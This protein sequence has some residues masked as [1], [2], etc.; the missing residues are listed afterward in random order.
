MRLTIEQRVAALERESVVLS[1]TVKLL[2]RLLKEQRRLINDYITKKV[3]SVGQSKGR[4]GNLRP[5]DELYMFV[6]KTRFERLE[7]QVEK[8]R[9]LVEKQKF[10]LRAG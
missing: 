5:E 7:K 10:G 2:H 9:K 1:D 6:C 4:E 8:I 3:T